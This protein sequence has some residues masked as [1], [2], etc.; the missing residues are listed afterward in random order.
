MSEN[1]KPKILIFCDYYLPG[2]KSGG[3]MRTIVNMVDR[4]A[5]KFDFWIITR[6]HD[7]KLDKTPYTTVKINEWNDVQKAKVF[8]LSKNNLKISK[9]RELIIEVSPNSLYFNSYFAT[10]TIYV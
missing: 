4:L 9:L 2:Y 5:D 3:G 6:D 8:Y 10:L 1:K 7:G